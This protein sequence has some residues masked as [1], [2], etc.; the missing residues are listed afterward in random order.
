MKQSHEIFFKIL[1]EILIVSSNS[2]QGTCSKA[3]SLYASLCQHDKTWMLQHARMPILAPALGSAITTNTSFSPS[4]H[5][6]ASISTIISTNTITSTNQAPAPTSTRAPVR[7][8]TPA[9]PLTQAPTS[10]ITRALAPNQ[11]QDHC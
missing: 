5:T 8:P 10:A 9:S 4:T 1:H 3:C 7:A 11:H 6:K 2:M